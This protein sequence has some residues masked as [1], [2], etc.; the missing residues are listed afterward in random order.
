MESRCGMAVLR[1]SRPRASSGS[2]SRRVPHAGRCFRFARGSAARDPGRSA[3]QAMDADIPAGR[4][5]AM[6]PCAI[7]P[8]APL[9]AARRS[10]AASSGILGSA[11]ARYRAVPPVR[12]VDAL[13][14]VKGI[15]GKRPRGPRPAANRNAGTASRRRSSPRHGPLRRLR[16]ISGMGIFRI[17]RDPRLRSRRSHWESQG[18]GIPGGQP[19]GQRDSE[20]GRPDTAD[21]PGV[22]GFFES[23]SR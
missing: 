20:S 3:K 22:P 10:A 9:K 2:G 17:G 11:R 21:A 14:A 13:R 6:A 18:T 16:P 8:P 1:G 4:G 12:P 7:R 5:P 19:P 23:L 15:R